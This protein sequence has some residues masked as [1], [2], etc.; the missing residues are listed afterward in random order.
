M[1]IYSTFKITL[2]GALLIWASC[3]AIADVYKW[4]DKDG[5]IHY[6]DQ[7]PLAGDAK[8]MKQK[9]KDTPAASSSASPG[10]AAT[11]PA[12]SAADQELEFR[13]RK[14]EKEEAEKKQ[15]ADAETAKKNKEYCNNLLGDLRSHSDGT[16][17]VRY[18]DKGERIFLDEK[19][20]SDSKKQLENRIAKDCK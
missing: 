19:E 7:P 12:S 16:R 17:L 8:K 1:K 15:Q 5:K 9:S 3:G 4:V 2:G 13:K 18:N 14:T 11:K 20:R 10:N 6:S